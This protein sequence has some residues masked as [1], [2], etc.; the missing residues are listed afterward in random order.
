MKTVVLLGSVNWFHAL[1]VSERV[2]EA[3][4]PQPWRRLI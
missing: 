2:N 1:G 4:G 3:E